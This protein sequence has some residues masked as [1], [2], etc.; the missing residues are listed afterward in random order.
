ML[1]TEPTYNIMKEI[2]KCSVTVT[3]QMKANQQILS[4]GVVHFSNILYVEMLV[5]VVAN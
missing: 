5:D 1:T 3:V 4:F 2:L